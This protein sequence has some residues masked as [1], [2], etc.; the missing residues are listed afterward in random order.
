MSDAYENACAW[1][2]IAEGHAR[3]VGWGGHGDT[4]LVKAWGA[5]WQLHMSAVGALVWLLE[6]AS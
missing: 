3:Q 2:S 1:H 6:G 5:T 4:V